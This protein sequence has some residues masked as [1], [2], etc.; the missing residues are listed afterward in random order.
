M[1]VFTIRQDRI[2]LPVDPIILPSSVMD[3]NITASQFGLDPLLDSLN[4]DDGQLV[5]ADESFEGA[6]LGM[7]T[8]MSEIPV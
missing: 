8:P 5:I 1:L 4:L 3:L 6:L 7:A 2:D